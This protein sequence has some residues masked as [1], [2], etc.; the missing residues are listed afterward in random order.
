MR[1]LSVAVASDGMMFAPNP[2][3]HHRQRHRIAQHRVV[4]RVAA[5]HRG[6]L[7]DLRLVA[8]GADGLHRLSH[9]RILFDLREPARSTRA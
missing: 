9:G 1:A 6:S 2:A 3:V 5:Q 4:H 8:R 7:V